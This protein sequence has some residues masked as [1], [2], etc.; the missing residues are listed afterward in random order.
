MVKLVYPY[1]GILLSNK[2]GIYSTSGKTLKRIKL[3]GKKDNVE[4]IYY[5]IYITFLKWQK[6][7]NEA[8]L[9]VARG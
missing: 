3:S 6:H 1:H 4:V 8:R 5:V 2:K 7:R 9:V